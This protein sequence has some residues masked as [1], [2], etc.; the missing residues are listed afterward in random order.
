M[1]EDGHGR[2][3][4]RAGPQ[5]TFATQQGQK[6]A[7]MPGE[8]REQAGTEEDRQET[9]QIGRASKVLFRGLTPHDDVIG[10][11]GLGHV[12][13]VGSNTKNLMYGFGLDQTRTFLGYFNAR[14]GRELEFSDSGKWLTITFVIDEGP[15]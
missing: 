4:E 14:I 7:G 5:I 9:P 12:G 11:A 6:A 13:P 15:R 10:P 2:G 8:D 1:R 3:D